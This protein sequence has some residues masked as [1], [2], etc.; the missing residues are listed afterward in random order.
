METRTCWQI[1]KAVVNA[2]FL[3]ELK[4]R[5]GS[6]KFGYFWAIMEPAAIIAVFWVMF[7]LSLRKTLPGI[8]YPMFLM[9]G[10]LPWQLFANITNRSMAAFEANRGLF[11]YRQVKPIDPLIARVFVEGLVYFTVFLLFMSLGKFLGF[12]AAIDDIFGLSLILAQLLFFSFSFGLLC[13]VI[14][15][16]SENYTKIIKI[17]LRPLFFSSGIF[18]TV[19]TVPDKYKWLLL[20]NPILHFME[21][22]RTYYFAA[23][24]TQDASRIYTIFWTVGVSI[25]ALWLYSKLKNKIIAS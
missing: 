19:A 17:M 21:L 11:N 4:T 22:I 25:L 18:F 20:W 2:L 15:T 13:A 7:G 24:Q 12:D 8:D 1:Q 5:F 14:G 6:Q 23:F 16:F 9:T 10:M 3:R